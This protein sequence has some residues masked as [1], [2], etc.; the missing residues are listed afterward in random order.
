MHEQITVKQLVDDHT[1]NLKLT[2]LAGCDRACSTFRRE[3]EELSSLV[4]YL[5]FVHPQQICVLGSQEFNYLARQ[6]TKTYTE[7]VELIFQSRPKLIIL[8]DGQVSTPEIIDQA[9][10]YSIPLI[11]SDCHSQA[12][13][14]HLSHYLSLKLASSLTVHGVFMEVLDLGVL[15]TGDSGVGKS[16]LALELITRGHRLVADDTPTLTRFTPD[17]I[18]GHCP[19]LLQDF[20]EV[21]GLGVLN[22]KALYGSTAIKDR[23]QVHLIVRIMVLNDAS[24]KITDRLSGMNRYCEILG[25]EIPEVV[26]PLAPGRNLAILVEAA[27]RNQ[28]LKL[29]GYDSSKLFNQ[30]QQSE[31]ER[32][33]LASEEEN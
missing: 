21:R 11:K 16:E 19:P 33:A 20:L 18:T 10:N 29:S 2:W 7:S 31:L 14:D 1:D 32:Q 26:I 25:V 3:P 8:A 6:D 13:V 23:K 28:V 30:R 12:V 15:L 5:N 4:G 24:L 22:V 27:V 17:C 9:R